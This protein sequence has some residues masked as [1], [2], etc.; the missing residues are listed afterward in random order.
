MENKYIEEAL[1]RMQMSLGKMDTT[2]LNPADA[3]IASLFGKLRQNL[4]APASAPHPMGGKTSKSIL[5][6]VINKGFKKSKGLAALAPILLLLL[7]S[8]RKE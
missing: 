6:Y 1:L 4:G 5:D 2:D 8:Q 7:S 3:E